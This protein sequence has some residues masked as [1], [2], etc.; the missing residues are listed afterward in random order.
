M[1]NGK[2]VKGWLTACLQGDMSLW[3]HSMR[4]G[5]MLVFILLM[6]FMLV[7]SNATMIG[8]YGYKV[9][10]G[11]TLFT[12]LNSGFNLI[13][14]SVAFLVMISEIPKRVS[15][16]KYVLIRLS[17]GKWL[18][19]LIV[20]CI[21]IVAFFLLFMTAMCALFSL[22]YVTPGSGWSDLERLAE[23]AD[24]I[25]EMQ[26]IPQYIRGLS[27]FQACFLAWF[28]L[29]C[30]FLTM[31]LLIL[32]FSLFEMPN[33][34][35]VVCVSL[36]LLNITVLFEY[37]PGIVLPSNFATLGAIVS[38]KPEHEFEM[39]LKVLVGYGIV[40][41]LI[42]ALMSFRVKKMDMQF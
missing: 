15:Y 14:T 27:P 25:Y 16:Q 24:Y 35:I 5:L 22:S 28:V 41:A 38:V 9:H 29:F 4:T 3:L 34:G 39:L 20:F 12:C 32:S 10:L 13:M 8:M 42:I 18:L 17:R 1:L 21:G 36:L 2:K 26:I 23:N 11:E 7:R 19:S 30:F 37:L 33:L 40:D 31:T 6:N